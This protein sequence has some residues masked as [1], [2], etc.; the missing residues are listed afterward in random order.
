[1]QLVP[2]EVGK[3]RIYTL[4]CAFA[5]FCIYRFKDLRLGWPCSGGRLP[6]LF[7]RW[8]P[9]FRPLAPPEAAAA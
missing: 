4:F 1:M 7:Q 3:S 9:R 5:G 8:Y 2:T 6:Q